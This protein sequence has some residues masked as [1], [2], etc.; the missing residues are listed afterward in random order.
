[1]AVCVG[2]E[3]VVWSSP[4]KPGCRTRG[5]IQLNWLW[6]TRGWVA[7]SSTR[8]EVCCQGRV[9]SLATWKT[10]RPKI[11]K[12]N[13]FREALGAPSYRNARASLWTVRAPIRLGRTRVTWNCF[14]NTFPNWACC[15]V[16]SHPG[17]EPY[18]VRTLKRKEINCTIK[19]PE[20]P[21][22]SLRG[23]CTQR[24]LRPA[25]CPYLL[26]AMQPKRRKKKRNTAEK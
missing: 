25:P 8:T 15:Q 11:I 20:N 10:V 3:V 21:I 4:R 2:L 18:T 7:K 22:D 13:G 12:F 19:K 17:T 16:P 6:R 23:Y 1:M 14:K 26:L 24:L 5:T 9:T